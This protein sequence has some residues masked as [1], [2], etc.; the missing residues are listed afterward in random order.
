TLDKIA[1]EKA[2]IFKP[3]VPAI[4]CEQPRDAE[5]ALKL[6]AEEIGANLRIINKDI[7][8]SF[9]FGASDELGPHTRVCL[10]TE[11]SQFMHLP[12]PLPGEHQAI[13]CAM[14]LAAVDALKG[15]GFNIPE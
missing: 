12:V 6:A 4:T 10:I 7:E 5:A 1:R 13:H 2:G 14:A 9:R 11:T 3:G 8:F 15:C